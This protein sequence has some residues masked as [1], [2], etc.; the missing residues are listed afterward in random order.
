M[1]NKKKNSNHWSRYTLMSFPLAQ[2]IIHVQHPRTI[3][4]VCGRSHHIP[5]LNP[6]LS[7]SLQMCPKHTPIGRPRVERSD[8]GA[9]PLATP[10]A[11]PRPDR[12]V[13][14]FE[15]SRLGRLWFPLKGGFWEVQRVDERRS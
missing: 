12:I 14:V 1:A 6:T 13:K 2:I 15:L 8:R 10:A 7:I 9:A 4:L 11:L 3:K 5:T